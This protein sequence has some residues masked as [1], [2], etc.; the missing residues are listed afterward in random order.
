MKCEGWGGPCDR[1]DA[2]LNRQNTSYVED[3][4]NYAILC[5]ECQEAADA[6]W[7]ERW[8]E[9]YSGQGVGFSLS[10]NPKKFDPFT[11]RK[12]PTPMTRY[13]ILLKETA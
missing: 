7:Q 6:E 8:D 4:R 3:E 13:E 2:T 5:P 9:Y 11:E 12:R 1:I 10:D